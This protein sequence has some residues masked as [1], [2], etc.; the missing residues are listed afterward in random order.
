MT[1]ASRGPRNPPAS[2][3][4]I[5]CYYGAVVVSRGAPGGRSAACLGLHGLEVL[6]DAAQIEQDE[7]HT[8]QEVGPDEH[9]ENPEPLAGADRLPGRLRATGGVQRRQQPHDHEN[10]DDRVAADIE[11]AGHRSPAR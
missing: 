11:E 5:P 6:A 4:M 9:P 7:D 2:R 8:D 3:A 1:S 10:A